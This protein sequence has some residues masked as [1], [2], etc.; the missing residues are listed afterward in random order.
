M[1]GLSL[2]T[3][4]WSCRE[5]VEITA[6]MVRLSNEKLVLLR[7][8]RLVSGCPLPQATESASLAIRE[9]RVMLQGLIGAAP[10]KGNKRASKDQQSFQRRHAE[11]KQAIQGTEAQ[12]ASLRMQL[13]EL[14][15]HMAR[16]MTDQGSGG[17][18]YESYLDAVDALGALVQPSWESSVSME[19]DTTADLCLGVSALVT[20]VERNLQAL[21]AM[22]EDLLQSLQTT[23]DKMLRNRRQA[24][25]LAEIDG[26]DAAIASQRRVKEDLERMLDKIKA[27]SDMVLKMMIATIDCLESKNETTRNLP[28]H[29]SRI[30]FYRSIESL[31]ER[32]RSRHCEIIS[33][34]ST[35]TAAEESP[36]E[37]VRL[38]EEQLKAATATLQQ[39]DAQLAKFSKE[40][41]AANGVHSAIQSMDAVPATAVGPVGS[42]VG[43]G[44]MPT[45]YGMMTEDPV[46]TM[47]QG[48]VQPQMAVA[49]SVVSSEPA[50]AAPQPVLSQPQ[51]PRAA[52]RGWGK[53]EATQEVLDE[54]LPSLADAKAA[55]S[56]GKRAHKR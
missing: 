47:V 28:G 55:S 52:P 3:A 44:L 25:W 19:D 56:K 4:L 10:K 6:E 18:G 12:L 46:C 17:A 32:I 50:I 54:T 1:R 22:Q 43:G 23:L 48:T 40:P 20:A 34:L 5:Q 11:L 37:R 33:R 30:P 51:V 24:R 29:A 13:S 53:V 16:G 38:L 8:G 27:D 7:N 49:A 42:A 45:G 39:K 15:A 21:L 31:A 2:L 35:D 26:S 9:L 14:E 41:R 36:D